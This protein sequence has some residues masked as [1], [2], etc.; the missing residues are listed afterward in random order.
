MIL[1]EIVRHVAAAWIAVAILLG[2][3]ELAIPGIFLIFLAI[4]AAITGLALFALPDLPLIAQLGSFAAWSV[5]SVMIGRRWY[6]DYPLETSDPMLNNR[7]ARVI[8]ATVVIA[9]PLVGG[10]GRAVLG[11]GTWPATGPDAA[12]GTHM[13][14]IAVENGVLRL[15]PLDSALAEQLPGETG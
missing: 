13:R 9:E 8:G 3:A 6:R 11:D 5:V 12:A 4:A 7:S 15:E 2:I 10:S 1:D 14:I